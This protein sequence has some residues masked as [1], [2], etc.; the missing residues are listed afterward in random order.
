MAWYRLYQLQSGHIR[1]G[2][3]FDAAD[4][5]AALR[6]AVEHIIFEAVELWCGAKRIGMIAAP[7]KPAK[8]SL[9]T[10]E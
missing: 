4:D 9:T 3:D 7:M 5:D 1:L 2:E 6:Y 10:R 8:P